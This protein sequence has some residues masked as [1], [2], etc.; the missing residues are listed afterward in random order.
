M[1][2]ILMEQ[3]RTNRI[4][5]AVVWTGLGFAMGLLVARLLLRLHEMGAF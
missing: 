1:M 2:A 4:L 3:R 5:S